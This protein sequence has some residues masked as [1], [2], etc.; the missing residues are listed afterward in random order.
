METHQVVNPKTE[1]VQ[2]VVFPSCSGSPAVFCD[3]LTR[4]VRRGLG[5]LGRMRQVKRP[6]SWRAGVTLRQV[7][8]QPTQSSQHQ[9]DRTLKVRPR[10]SQFQLP[11][12][13]D[14]GQLIGHIR[15]GPQTRRLEGT[16]LDVR[17]HQLCGARNSQGT[18]PKTGHSCN[19]YPVK[20]TQPT[21]LTRFS[22]EDQR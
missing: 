8:F 18:N 15:E 3:P 2:L 22:S 4:P 6:R 11:R 1:P 10:A 17:G 7:P 20:P 5:L 12:G 21:F 19:W 14:V 9:P 13:R 16:G